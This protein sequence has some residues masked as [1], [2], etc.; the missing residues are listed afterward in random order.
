ML[1]KFYSRIFIFY[2]QF[3]LIIKRW[4]DG[5]KEERIETWE[6]ENLYFLFYNYFDSSTFSI[7]NKGTLAHFNMLTYDHTLSLINILAWCVPRPIGR[8]IKRSYLIYTFFLAKLLNIYLKL[9]ML[10]IWY[11][12]WSI[13]L[14]RESRVWT[15]K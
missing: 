1:R 12:T 13:W 4:F 3:F 15:N 14:L 10:F 7:Q 5:K 2:T 8:K 9:K 6:T 11:L